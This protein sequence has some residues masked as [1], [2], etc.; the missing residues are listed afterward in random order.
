MIAVDSQDNVYVSDFGEN[1]N[2]QKIHKN[3]N[4]LMKIGRHGLT[5]GYFYN[6]TGIAIDSIGNI[7]V[8][9]SGNDRIQKSDKNGNFVTKIGK[10]G[11]N[12]GEFNSSIGIAIDSNDNIFVI[13][14]NNERIQVFN[15]DCTY[16]TQFGKDSTNADE[17]LQDHIGIALDSSGYVYIPDG[18]DSDVHFFK[19]VG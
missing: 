17:R 11:K 16:I 1:S 9:D 7:F 19:P 14:N 13:Y 6:P 12:N 5:D 3:G 18:K 2:V 10:P 15:R 8:A 4:F